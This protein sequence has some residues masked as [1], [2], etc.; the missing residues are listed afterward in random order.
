[1]GVI[2]RTVSF[3]PACASTRAVSGPGLTP[4]QIAI[5]ELLDAGQEGGR[6][7]LARRRGAHRG[8]VIDVLLGSPADRAGLAPGGREVAVNGRWQTRETVADALE[9]TPGKGAVELLVEDAF[10]HLGPEE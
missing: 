10:A 9:A 6:D 1:L 3:G 5:V 2:F 7:G 8:E 4:S